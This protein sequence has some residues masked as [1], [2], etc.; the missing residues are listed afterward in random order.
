M[1]HRV[2]AGGHAAPVSHNLVEAA[3]AVDT[4][5]AAAYTPR[6]CYSPSPPF[7]ILLRCQV[8]LSSIKSAHLERRPLCLKERF[9]C[10]SL[11][12]RPRRPSRASPLPRPPSSLS[13][14]WPSPTASPSARTTANSPTSLAP[15]A[16]PSSSSTLSTPRRASSPCSLLLLAAAPRKPPSLLKKS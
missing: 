7:A 6:D 11:R 3:G 1:V 14:A 2:S 15:R 4:G 8:L 13:L 5:F 16:T 9:S 12:R 10:P